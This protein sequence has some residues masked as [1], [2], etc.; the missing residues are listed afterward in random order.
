LLVDRV[1]F[2]TDAGVRNLLDAGLRNLTAD[3]IGLLAVT[4][5][6]LHA[7]AGNRSRFGTRYPAAAGHG[8]AGLF[9]SDFAAA[10]F[11]AATA[12]ARIPFPGSGIADAL[13]HSRTRNL[14]RFRD[15][16]TGAVRNLLRF[17]NWFADGV[18]NVAI[19]GLCFGAVGR[20]ANFFVLGF[21]N[22]LADVAADVAIAGVDDGLT[23]GAAD[24][25]VASLVARLANGAADIA[26]AGLHT[27]LAD[28][29]ADFL[30]AGLIY[31]FANRIAFVAIARFMNRTSA[32]H[33]N[34]FRALIINR[35]ATIDGTLFVD[36]FAY[37]FV[38]RPTAA[39]GGT[40]VTARCSSRRGTTIVTGG[41]TIRGFCS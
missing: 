9:A 29:A 22:W 18:A 26:I 41:A 16:F 36:R 38:A 28:R 7:G 4:D 39:L 32:G 31:G 23:D 30:V 21:A 10:W 34:L 13:V 19:A 33:R 40:I 37:C 35:T 27:G 5:F 20:A 11:V 3:R 15:P 2:P 14:F 25:A 6:L 8:A 1:L 12:F 17:A 24:I